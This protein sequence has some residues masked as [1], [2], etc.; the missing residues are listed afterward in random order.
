MRFKKELLEKSLSQTSP[1]LPDAPPPPGLD[2]LIQSFSALIAL[3]RETAA[4]LPE[5][6]VVLNHDPEGLAEG[7]PLLSSLDPGILARGVAAAGIMLPALGSLFPPAARDCQTLALALAHDPALAGR[8]LTVLVDDAQEPLLQLAGELDLTP[9]AVVFLTRELLAAVLR[10]AAANL[11]PLVDDA[12]WQRGRC[13]I[14][15]AAP[16]VGMLKEKAE[17]SEFLIAK[18]G[19]LSLHCSLCGHL[20]QFSRQICPGCGETGHE[21]RDL[22]LAEGRERERIHTCTACG[23]YLLVVN[24]VESDKPMDMDLAPVLLLHL[25]IVAQG[26]GYLPL[27]VTAW[28]QFPAEDIA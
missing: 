10:Q 7:R 4:G 12:T 18:S 27:A 15:G 11:S 3:R 6:P 9:P 2:A 19:H 16:D 1:D 28:N 20:W 14:C 5:W 17:T 22:Y 23:Q 24:R 21:R 25:D 8:L 13:P 26:K